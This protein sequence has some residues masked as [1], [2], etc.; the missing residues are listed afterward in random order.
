[1]LR[2]ARSPFIQQVNTVLQKAQTGDEAPPTRLF[3]KSVTFQVL[4]GDA[5]V[6]SKKLQF[7]VI[8]A[9]A[10]IHSIQSF[11]DAGSSPA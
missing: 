3:R 11:L 8:P 10:G 5:L 6:K 4:S 7:G 1:V 2:L 9:Q